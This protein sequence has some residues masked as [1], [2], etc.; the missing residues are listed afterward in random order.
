MI[1]KLYPLR[2][3]QIR[4]I[5]DKKHNYHYKDDAK[6]SFFCDECGNTDLIK[7]P[8]RG[9]LICKCGLSA[10]V[11]KKK[12]KVP[13]ET[14]DYLTF[15]DWRMFLN[16]LIGCC[17]LAGMWH[18]IMLW[19]KQGGKLANITDKNVEEAYEKFG[20]DPN[21]PSTDKGV[22]LRN[23]LKYWKKYGFKDA[24]GILHKIAA[25]ARVNFTDHD[26]VK[27][28]QYLF[29]GLYM[30]FKVPK[31]VMKLFDEGKIWD[32]QNTDTDI[33][34]LH[35]V[36][37]TGYGKYKKEGTASVVGVEK[38]GVWVITWGKAVFMTW[39]F[40]DRYVDELW[41]VFDTEM[42]DNSKSPDGFDSIQLN[43]LLNKIAAEA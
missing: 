32:V 39:A 21:N 36:T 28:A 17:G 5:E 8:S 9:E 16:D 41:V 43:I 34:G 15:K 24:D 3:C 37:P 20:Y 40:L 42:L 30:G 19:T 38:E 33:E 23:V 22:I 7:D 29:S 18:L 2:C 25:Y 13:D 26:E 12:I 27:L 1:R 11:D 6:I 4:S 35:C 31:F 10:L 14:T